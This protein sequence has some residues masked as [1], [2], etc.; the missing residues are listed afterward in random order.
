MRQ[1][2]VQTLQ[3][4]PIFGAVDA[5]TVVWLLDG[6]AVRD[7]D[8]GGYVFRE[9]DMDPSVYV[10]ELG[11]FTVFRHWQGTDYRLRELGPGDC[12]GEMA[13][14]DCQPRSA[15]VVTRHGGRLIQV[16]AV[17]LAE[18]YD[19]RPEQYTLIVMNLGRELCRRLRDA[20]RRLFLAELQGLRI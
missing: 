13:L 20:D 2:R 1:D 16:T 5:E 15:N 3:A 17:Q 18:L 19:R 14:M 8:P 6:A 12:F 7:I 10:I 9:G 11:R 4:M